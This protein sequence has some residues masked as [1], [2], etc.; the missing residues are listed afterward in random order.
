[1]LLVRHGRNNASVLATS[2]QEK[3]YN[4]S[5]KG[6]KR[7]FERLTI[8]INRLSVSAFQ[9]SGAAEVMT[10]RN[11]RYKVNPNIAV[12]RTFGVAER[13]DSRL[14]R[15]QLKP[16]RSEHLSHPKGLL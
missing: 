6:K 12:R 2:E 14:I 5:N 11:R 8:T 10:L 13:A 9:A 4:A 16:V 1:M 7:R 3:E 15:S